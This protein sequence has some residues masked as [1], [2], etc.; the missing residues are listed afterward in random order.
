MSSEFVPQ[1]KAVT[2]AFHP[3]DI[4]ISEEDLAAAPPAVRHIQ[5]YKSVLYASAY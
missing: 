5:K 1:E 4:E 3:E 2:A